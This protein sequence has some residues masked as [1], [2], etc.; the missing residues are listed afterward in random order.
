[1]INEARMLEEFFEL[2]RMDCPSGQEKSVAEVLRHRLESLGCTVAEDQAQQHFEGNCGNLIATLP[3]TKAS[4]PT[5]L[6]TS[7]MDCVSP[8]LSIQPRLENGRITSA[9]DTVL[10][11]DDKAGITAILEGLRALKESGKPH[12]AVQIVF[13]VHEEGG[14]KG[15]K[16]MDAALLKADFGYALDADGAPG[17]I[18]TMAPGQDSITAIVHGKKAHAGLA[19]EEGINAI[20][21]AGNALAALKIGRIDEETTANVGLIQGG[22]ATNI[23]PDHVEIQ[24]EARSR[25]LAK[26][27]AQSRHMKETVERVCQEYGASAEVTVQRQYDSFSLAP[28]SPAVSLAVAA[29][30]QINL[31]V[32]I[33][34]TGGGSD[35]NHFNRKGVP[36][37]VLGVGMKKVHTTEE[38]I[39]E[40]DLYDS[41]RF[42]LAILE[43]ASLS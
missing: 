24:A 13:T 4:A 35:A 28:D 5:V 6:F 19:P 12:G 40:K 37:A 29:A 9:G 43:Q 36:T 25:N 41:A 14:L 26:L 2:V 33:T 30:H 16:H 11:G 8:C 23:V 27:E 10:G 31:P 1:M 15:S 34:G 20:Q 7:H 38:Y 22:T 3:A 18:V 17:E 32:H 39:A 21:A 42:V